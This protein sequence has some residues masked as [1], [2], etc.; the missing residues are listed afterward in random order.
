MSCLIYV[1]IWVAFILFKAHLSWLF[2]VPCETLWF[3]QSLF[4]IMLFCT[5]ADMWRAQI[6]SQEGIR[7]WKKVWSFGGSSHCFQFTMPWNNRRYGRLPHQGR[8]PKM[9]AT[10]FMGYSSNTVI[11]LSMSTSYLRSPCLHSQS[12][13]DHKWMSRCWAHREPGEPW[14]FCQMQNQFFRSRPWGWRMHKG[15][16]FILN[17][18]FIEADD[19]VEEASIWFVLR[20][21]KWGSQIHLV[22]AET[23]LKPQYW[24]ICGGSPAVYSNQ[25]SILKGWGG[26]EE[27]TEKGAKGWTSWH[28]CCFLFLSPLNKCPFEGAKKGTANISNI[29]GEGIVSYSR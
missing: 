23:V 28:C 2:P 13:N 9:V 20:E 21:A 26:A 27:G 8:F 12:L 4:S 17:S 6:S 10:Y 18:T 7:D 29:F 22:S 25:G 5:H 24:L 14:A 1:G 15:K 11:H 3:I 16:G 19:S